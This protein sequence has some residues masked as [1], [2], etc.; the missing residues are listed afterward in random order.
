LRDRKGIALSLINLGGM[1]HDQQDF[2]SA[3]LL[4]EES[5][6]IVRELG[7]RWLGSVALSNLGDVAYEQGDLASARRLYEENLA[8]KRELGDR[9]GVANALVSLGFVAQDQGDYPAAGV[10][11][12]E[13]LTIARDLGDLR[14]IPRMLEGRASWVAAVGSFRRAACIFGAAERLRE[15]FGSPQSPNERNDFVKRVAT[16]RAC[17][18]DDA[19]FDGAWQEGR[20]L[21]LEQAIELALEKK[22]E[23]G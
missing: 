9:L 20:A 16:A 12:E 18:G 22:V 8:I 21:T 15:K 5:L 1:A 10:L 17:L 14:G 4:F 23:Q 7:D 3:R 13:S 19:A 6:A 11:Y 2:V